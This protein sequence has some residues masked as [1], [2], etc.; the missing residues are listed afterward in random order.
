MKKVAVK[1][2]CT[3]LTTLVVEIVKE[4]CFG[5]WGLF[6]VLVDEIK[7]ALKQMTGLEL[8]KIMTKATFYSLCVA[9]WVFIFF[10]ITF[11]GWAI[12]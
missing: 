7:T 1:D 11:V 12:I 10:G 8:V 5:L 4:V 9:C 2:F 6:W 3:A